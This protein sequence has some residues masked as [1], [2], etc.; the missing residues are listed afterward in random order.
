M[1]FALKRVLFNG[2]PIAEGEPSKV[3]QLVDE[4]ELYAFDMAVIADSE[5]D[6]ALARA[7]AERQTIRANYPGRSVSSG[8][9]GPLRIMRRWNDPDG[10][11]AWYRVG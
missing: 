8:L 7:Q 9:N 6:F 11:R 4:E 5:Q 2:R 3:I 1:S 10:K